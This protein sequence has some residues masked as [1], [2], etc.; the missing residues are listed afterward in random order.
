[1]R[2]R[3]ARKNP[4][5]QE[6]R[7]SGGVG[8]RAGGREKDDDNDDAGEVG[9]EGGG[10]GAKRTSRRQEQ[11]PE[12]CRSPPT[13]GRAIGHDHHPKKP[14]PSPTTAHRRNRGQGAARSDG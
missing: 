11:R 4:R 9:G 10:G 12:C 8:G 1:M 5:A 2:G 14:V 6:N 3:R 13:C 7:P